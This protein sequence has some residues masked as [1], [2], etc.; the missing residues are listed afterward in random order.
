MQRSISH[1][2]PV[3]SFVYVILF[4]LYDSLGSMNP[5]FPPLLAVL[6]IL[7]IKA[8]DKK[9]LISLL[10]VVI[11]LI[12]FEVNYG[13][14]LFSSVIYFYILYKI[15]MPKIAQNSSCSVCIRMFS[16]IL[17]YLGYFL[18]L[19]LLANVFLLPQPSLNYYIVYY[20]VIEFFLVS[21]L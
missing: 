7:F 9:D 3:V 18:F 6:Y 21:I 10:F 4:V 5:F 12:V 19:T 15:I 20:I 11:C 13:Y 8:L 1:Q 14:M 16:V 17:V 2:K